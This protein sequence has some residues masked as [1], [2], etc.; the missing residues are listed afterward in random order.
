MENFLI[1]PLYYAA[2]CITMPPTG[3]TV[4]FGLSRKRGQRYKTYGR[5]A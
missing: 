4:Q 5:I 3:F 1:A 2:K